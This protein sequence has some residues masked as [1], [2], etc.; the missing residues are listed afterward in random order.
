MKKKLLGFVS[1]MLFGATA[2]TAADWFF[3]PVEGTMT[4][5]VWTFTNVTA[6]A[7]DLTVGPC[8]NWPTVVF[9]IGLRQG[10][11]WTLATRSMPSLGSTRSL[12]MQTTNMTDAP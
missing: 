8:G 10:R 3:D 4:D 11:F 1:L 9:R 6:T 12:R 5:G 2:A 7:T